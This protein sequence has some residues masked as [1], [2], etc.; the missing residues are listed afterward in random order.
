MLSKKLS[1]GEY[2]QVLNYYGFHIPENIFKIRKIGNNIML[3]RMCLSNPKQNKYSK[4]I[5]VLKRRSIMTNHNKNI[6]NK[7]FRLYQ[8]RY[9]LTKKNSPISHL[10]I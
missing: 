10:L 3:K 2:V 6:N 5:S 4:L 8:S 9:N 7:T 1:I